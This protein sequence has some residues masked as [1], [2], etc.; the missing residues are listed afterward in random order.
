MMIMMNYDFNKKTRVI[1]RRLP[2]EAIPQVNGKA[3]VYNFK[4]ERM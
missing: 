4:I 1:A 2:D 3:F